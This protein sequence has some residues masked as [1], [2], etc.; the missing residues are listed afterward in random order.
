MLKFL[1]VHGNYL[2]D[3]NNIKGLFKLPTFPNTYL[4]HIGYLRVVKFSKDLTKGYLITLKVSRAIHR[5]YLNY[6]KAT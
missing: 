5:G 6:L 3:L 2:R 1:K 4:S